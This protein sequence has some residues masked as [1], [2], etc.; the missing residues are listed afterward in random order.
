MSHHQSRV[1][2]SDS[3][4]RRSA[5]PGG[6]ASHQ[7]ASTVKGGGAGG[8]GPSASAPL[9]SPA[10]QPAPVPSSKRSSGANGQPRG[11]SSA[12]IEPSDSQR[13]QQN[14]SSQHQGQQHGHVQSGTRPSMQPSNGN[15]SRSSRPGTPSSS[16]SLGVTEA[17]PA[18]PK[19]E[20]SWSSVHPQLS[21]QFGSIGPSFGHNTG[22]QIPA[23][24][25]SA[26]PNLDEQKQDQA[27]FEAV[28]ATVIKV[29]VSSGGQQQGPRSQVQQSGGQQ[30]GLRS[31]AQQSAAALP[32]GIP[33]PQYLQNQGQHTMQ[34]QITQANSHVPAQAAVT[35]QAHLPMQAHLV[36]AQAQQ[37]GLVQLPYSQHALQSQQSLMQHNAGQVLKFPQSMAGPPLAG[38]LMGHQLASLP[39]QLPAQ[40][41]PQMPH[42]LSGALAGTIA[43]GM[44][45][46]PYGV[47]PVTNH[48][49]PPRTSKAVKIVHPET[50]EEL[51]FDSKS[52]KG[53]SLTDSG[54]SATAALSQGRVVGN[55]PSHTRS[56]L[57]YVSGA[58]HQINHSVYS[59]LNGPYTHASQNYFQ[60]SVPAIST[61]V[62][63]AGS[64]T[65][66]FSEALQGQGGSLPSTISPVLTASVSSTSVETCG[67]ATAAV[68]SL[69]G[70]IQP[71]MNVSAE[72]KKFK[73]ATSISEAIEQDK[74]SGVDVEEKP[75]KVGKSEGSTAPIGDAERVQEPMKE[76]QAESLNLASLK[77]IYRTDLS[78]LSTSDVKQGGKK[79]KKKEGSSK[80]NLGD[81]HKV[82]KASE[83][84]KQ[85]EGKISDTYKAKVVTPKAEGLSEVNLGNTANFMEVIMPEAADVKSSEVRALVAGSSSSEPVLDNDRVAAEVRSMPIVSA[86]DKYETKV[87]GTIAALVPLDEA[88]AGAS[89]EPLVNNVHKVDVSMHESVNEQVPSSDEK[90]DDKGVVQVESS[91]AL[92]PS[93]TSVELAN[94]LSSGSLDTVEIAE[95][96]R[97]VGILENTLEAT[98]DV[99]KGT[100]EVVENESCIETVL[101]ADDAISPSTVDIDSADSSSL[102]CACNV[103][104]GTQLQTELAEV[105]NIV[106]AELSVLSS[107]KEGISGDTS[108]VATP[109]IRHGSKKKKMKDI[110]A[111]ADAAGTTADLYNAYKAPEE[112]KSDEMVPSKVD[113][114]K[115]PSVE[116]VKQLVTPD[117][118][119]APKELDDWEDAV[120]LP[121]PKA[122]PG[123]MGT[124]LGDSSRSGEKLASDIK[125]GETYTRDFLLTFKDQNMELPLDFEV[126]ADI[127][128]LLLNPQ[129]AFSQF[130]ERDM[131]S[132][133]GRMLDRQ[134]SSGPRRSNTANSFEEER[135]ARQPQGLHSPVWPDTYVDTGPAGGFRPGNA[136]G[137]IPRM[138]SNIRP[139]MSVPPLVSGLIPG[140]PLTPSA[141]PGMVRTNTVDSDRWQRMPAGQKGLIPSPQTPLPPV[142]KA[143]KRYEVGKSSDEEDSKQRQM[144][145]ILNK[146]TPQNFEKLFE[147]VKDVKIQSAATLTGVIS[148]IFDKALTEPT[149]CEM[150]ATFCRQLA[151]DM[152]EFVENGEKVTFKRVLLNKCQEEFHRGEREQAEASAV[153]EDGK[154]KITPEEREEKRL[155]AKRRM[156]GNIRFIGELYKK[157]MLTERI[158]HE[159]I[160]KLLGEYENP[161]EE[162]VEALCKLMS[163]IGH[164]I[165]H[166]KA[167]EHIDAYFD[168]MTRFS[169]NQKLS[170][171]IRFMLKDVIDLRRNGWQ[172]RRKVEGPKKIEEVHRDA[173]Q[174]RQATVAQAGRM[175]RGPSISASAGRRLVSPTEFSVRGLPSPLFSPSTPMGSVSQL[176]G[177]RGQPQIGNRGPF[178]QDVR[179][180]DR[181]LVESRP[182]PMPLSQRSVDEG[183]ITLGPQGGLGRG[184]SM[185]GQPSGSGRSVL[186]DMSQG[187]VSGENRRFGP[188]SLPAYSS[189]APLGAERPLTPPERPLLDR[190]VA[191]DRYGSGSS[192]RSSRQ[193]ERTL[194]DRAVSTSTASTT[195]HQLQGLSSRPSTAPAFV[196]LSEEQLKKKSEAALIEYFSARD[197]KEAAQCV[198][199]LRAPKF[200]STMVETWI[201]LS[202]DKNNLERELLVK[203]LIS[204]HKSEPFLLKQEQILQ[205]FEMVME[206]LEDLAVDVPQAPEYLAEI[207]MRLTSAGVLLLDQVGGLL[208]RSYLVQSGVG[209]KMIGRMLAGL[210]Q[211]RGE[212]DFLELFKSSRI[213]F[214][215]FIIFDNPSKSFFQEYNLQCIDPE[216]D[217]G[218]SPT[219][220][221]VEK[222]LLDHLS[223]NEPISETLR[224]L[225]RSITPPMQ[226]DSTFL[227]ML[228]TQVLKHSISSSYEKYEIIKERLSQ[229]RILLRRFA[230]DKEKQRQYIVAMQ[231]FVHDIGHPM[232]LMT[233]LFRTFY[234]QEVISESAYVKWEDDVNDPTLGREKALRDVYKWLIWLKTAPE[235]SQDGEF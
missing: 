129:A 142:H 230:M 14:T 34:A 218:T 116:P 163:T 71:V 41:I 13:A 139:G 165:D 161:E 121:S 52:S 18:V 123:M 110:L 98:A 122:P 75:S 197:L 57:G 8:H 70:S 101:I 215:D 205:G 233:T 50:H 196:P 223:R 203:L 45:G 222:Q 105:H 131:L 20:S 141:I 3:Q 169:N 148:Q 109:D 160:R 138:P 190:P 158:M 151:V 92:S 63:G 207:L 204:L 44:P 86:N 49:I 137:L 167:K 133:S 4:Q 149:F 42:Q 221:Q 79:K 216:S 64:T 150:Y 118:I 33:Q 194:S 189:G 124:E 177:V 134:L 99:N 104:E 91:E 234:E 117:E 179:M 187:M 74:E 208:K 220:Q 94:D 29:P 6:G 56:S 209:L 125:Q 213:R 193:L 15:V 37:Q 178:V 168:R 9:L 231:L 214:E 58:H 156:L 106:N 182:V 128:E 224:W 53:D 87:A 212:I 159:C 157:H 201:A 59:T 229:Y 154:E 226:S 62:T 192:N 225:E 232:G 107:M 48:F 135:W 26:P 61:P 173:V 120:E 195:H 89:L 22:M 153:E 111:K 155:K 228:M 206:L 171:R 130:A 217:H 174:E 38:Q 78:V 126:R 27:R 97:V 115:A 114:S 83:G 68:Q 185:R 93:A 186:T 82:S 85:A 170:S 39:G 16:S 119:S 176:G 7:R 96:A 60:P 127:A 54:V 2:R 19:P 219:I 175:S 147:Q 152:P 88:I 43:S 55:G 164:M 162:D 227:Q 77:D 84:K 67:I 28:N 36:P 69:S 80:A 100:C 210:R 66:S 30:Q 172:E 183:P 136:Q 166:T 108:V 112:K 235:Q 191:A 95:A 181:F 143:E 25:S 11:Y 51:R 40:Q 146:L 21:F 140:K 180:E 73:V 32:A 103:E 200:Y 65:H 202:L 188:V 5:R 35:T 76:A 113:I 46:A 1:D 184:A 90:Q 24:T 12:G 81:A 145:G 47:V 102:N 132:G 17:I 31:Q 23:R 199:D 198:E 211:D 10:V 72:D 144:K